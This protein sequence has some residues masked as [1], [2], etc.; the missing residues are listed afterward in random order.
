MT[1][2]EEAYK[3]IG[4]EC[5]AWGCWKDLSEYEQDDVEAGYEKVMEAGIQIGL[6]ESKHGEIA[7]ATEERILEMLRM[8]SVKIGLCNAREMADWIE[9]ELRKGRT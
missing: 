6:S 3:L 9:E 7:R 2:R 8:N 4:K 5:Q 1:T